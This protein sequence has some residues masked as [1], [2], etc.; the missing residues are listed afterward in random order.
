MAASEPAQEKRV[1]RGTILAITIAI[2]SGA[3]T[4]LITRQPPESPPP[5]QALNVRLPDS[6]TLTEVTIAPDGSQLVYAAITNGHSSLFL[7]SFSTFSVEPIPGTEHATQ[8]FF[9][10]DGSRV[11][12]FASG[13]LRWVA[14]DGGSPVSITAVDGETAGAAWGTDNHIIFAPLGGRGLQR[15]SA[16]PTGNP[17]NPA[18][19]QVSELDKES[20]EVS[21]GWPVLLPGHQS[22]IFTVG[23]FDRDPR[24]AWMNFNSSD[25]ELIMPTDGAA[26]YVDSGHLVF[27]RRGELFATP[28]DV[29]NQEVAGPTR[30]VAT[31]V[32]STAVGFDLLGWSNLSAARNGRLIYTAE[33]SSASDDNLLVWVDR[34][35]TVSDIDGVAAA[36]HTPRVASDESAITMTVRSGTFTRDLWVYDIADDQRRQVTQAAGDNHSPIWSND[37]QWI[38][39]ASNRGGPQ[40]VYRVA[41]GNYSRVEPLLSGDGRTPGSW[42]PDDTHLFFH[43]RGQDRRRDS[44]V[45]NP[46]SGEEQLLL[47]TTAN[48]RSPA[49]SPNGTWLAYVS[50]AAGGNQIY[51]RSVVGESNTRISLAGGVEPVWSGNSTELF[52]RRGHDLFSVEID[53]D[54]GVPSRAQ[55]QF[56]GLFVNDPGGNVPAYDVSEDGSRFLMLRTISIVNRL[57]VVD[58]WQSTVFT[59]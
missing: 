16:A 38:T 4:W 23:R 3:A 46:Q 58:H 7:R 53:R 32:Q 10:P 33:H 41:R 59:E 30:L 31:G 34:N 27:A 20:G 13:F 5:M 35:G 57:A 40:S 51:L 22:I 47:G 42:S 11:G 19:T 52:Y 15:V 45:W 24:L 25:R 12:F 55:H 39:F 8:P 36:H 18:V 50:D 48:E 2:V 49:I 9:S 29:I 26:V 44:W 1:L 6:H 54:T 43:E 37:N 21:H 56:A 14:L 17:P 28:I